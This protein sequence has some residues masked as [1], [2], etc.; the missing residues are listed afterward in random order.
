MWW[1][2]L[3]LGRTVKLEVLANLQDKCPPMLK[4]GKDEVREKLPTDLA[5]P[6][7]PSPVLLL[8]KEHRDSHKADFEML[9]CS[10]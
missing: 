2:L 4:E 6:H 7:Q 5:S 1:E 8:G 9:F 3:S 10:W